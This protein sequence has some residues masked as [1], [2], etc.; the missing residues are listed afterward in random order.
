MPSQRCLTSAQEVQEKLKFVL[1]VGLGGFSNSCFSFS[2]L[3]NITGR[4]GLT[5]YK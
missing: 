3:C 4:A 1:Q 5:S 2:G